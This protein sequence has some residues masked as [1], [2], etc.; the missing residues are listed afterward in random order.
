MVDMRM[1][2]I[3]DVDMTST[4]DSLKVT[5]TRD[6]INLTS[7]FI[8]LNSDFYDAQ[9]KLDLSRI[10]DA[11]RE[12]RQQGRFDLIMVDY[13]YGDPGELNGISII[14]G[15]RE[16]F[17]EERII[18]YSGLRKQVIK[19]LIQP[20]RIHRKEGTVDYEQIASSFNKLMQMKIEAFI[21]RDGFVSEATKML[22]QKKYKDV[23]ELLIDKLSQHT[24]LVVRAQGMR[25]INGKTLKDIID[26]LNSDVQAQNWLDE[27]LD[28]LIAYLTQIYESDSLCVSRG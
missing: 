24:D 22:K 12:E 8:H 11:V 6:Q 3:D 28:E 27:I 20:E 14:R 21:R 4:T 25:G 23:K 1:L 10:L 15:L 17:P 2:V 26:S 7:S 18:L 19:D 13:D 9:D 16:V 5:L